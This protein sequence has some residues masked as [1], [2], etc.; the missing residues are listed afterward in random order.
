[1]IDLHGYQIHEAWQVFNDAVE[2]A[3]LKGH[4]KVHVV[5]GQGAMM[6][7][8]PTWAS[9]NRRVREF[10]QNQHNPGSFSVKLKKAQKPA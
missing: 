10:S 9:N 4:K 3:Y 7:E 5:T 8:F 6:K 1:M 2:D